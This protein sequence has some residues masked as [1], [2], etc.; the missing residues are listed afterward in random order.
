MK[1]QA[2]VKEEVFNLLDLLM[3]NEISYVKDV[4]KEVDNIMCF[5]IEVSSFFQDRDGNIYSQND[6]LRKFRHL[7]KNERYQV[8]SNFFSDCDKGSLCYIWQFGIEINGKFE[9]YYGRE[10]KEFKTFIDSIN[11]TLDYRAY[12][13]IHNASY[14]M[15]F[16]ANIFD[17]EN[18]FLLLHGRRH[19]VP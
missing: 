18:D 13:F 5:D 2:Y 11:D 17:L 4:Y 9:T 8:L 1:K 3:D 6:I 10:L 19:N 12:C 14:E 15:E 16:L 7:E